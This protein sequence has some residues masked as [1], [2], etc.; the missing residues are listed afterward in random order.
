MNIADVT[1]IGAGISGS[2][3]AFLLGREQRHVQII[4][5]SFSE[6][7]KSCGEGLSFV[8]QR[9]LE[10]AGI[11]GKILDYSQAFYGF[12]IRFADN[13]GLVLP[14]NSP[15]G[16]GVPRN[17]LDNFLLESIATLPTIKIRKETALKFKRHG[18][19]WQ[20]ITEQCSYYSKHLVI[21]SGRAYQKLLGP[22][23]IDNTANSSLRYGLTVRCTGQWKSGC[24]PYVV[25]DNTAGVQTVLTPLQSNRVN[26]SMLVNRKGERK[27]KQTLLQNVFRIAELVGFENFEIEDCVGAS[28]LGSAISPVINDAYL[29]GDAAERFD[30]IGG[31]GLSH[32]LISGSLAAEQINSSLS[33]K[34]P[35]QVCWSRY[36]RRRKI[37]AIPLRLATGFSHALN[38]AQNP[39]LKLLVRAFPKISLAILKAIERLVPVVGLCAKSSRST[40]QMAQTSMAAPEVAVS[41]KAVT[42]LFGVLVLSAALLVGYANA[43]TGRESWYLPQNLSD[44]N[45]KITFKVDTTWHEVHGTTSGIRGNIKLASAPN[46][47]VLDFQVSV[48]AAS[49]MTGNESRDETLHEIMAAK[50]FPNISLAGVKEPIECLPAQVADD[51]QCSTTIEAT[52]Q[53]RSTAKR[54]RIPLVISHQNNRFIISG[55]FSI[56]W[57]AFGV[58]D[59][60]IFL[61]ARV[62]STV[63]VDFEVE[64]TAEGA[65]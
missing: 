32:A 3:T 55:K 46:P 41:T 65:D 36:V 63:Q 51:N 30:P 43:E 28:G 61:I 31:M 37:C 50:T 60:S 38:V 13:S 27:D 5:P 24:S 40:E 48:P 16:Y 56:D 22:S 58:E 64:L 62:N 29:V 7:R 23:G 11:W 17:A 6:D 52:L 26:I 1:I 20:V 59:P 10:Y 39:L 9:Y 15:M 19:L 34:L 4:D 14:G 53:I 45:A 12:K 18:D 35:Q 2:F 33:D 57:K 8:G 49:L 54:V 25:I 21:G 42:I 44:K 47:S